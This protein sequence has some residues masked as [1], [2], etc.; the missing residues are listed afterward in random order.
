M[1]TIDRMELAD[2]GNPVQL[3]K[4]VIGQ[5]S[6][7]IL[8]VPVRDIAASLDI[9]EIKPITVSGFE[10]G[11]ITFDDKSSGCILINENSRPQ[12]QRFTIGHELGHY[13]NP[14][15]N[16]GSEG[17]FMCKAQDM[18]ASGNPV[19]GRQKM[20]V[21]A[22]QFSAELLMPSQF[23][24]DDVKRLNAPEIDHIV[25]LAT[26]YDVSKESMGRR[27]IEFQDEPCALVF[28][29]NGKLSYMV[30]GQ[31]FPQLSIWQ[32]GDAIPE[33]SLTKTYNDQSGNSSDWREHA[34]DIWL[35]NSNKYESVYEQVLLQ[36][37]G[38]RIT[39]LTLGDEAD[40][41]EEELVA[42]YKPRFR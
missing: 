37:N 33:N 5:I 2:I 3:A 31:Y 32:K 40:E 9:A 10:G 34:S 28:S 42:S 12:R 24:R 26:K 15:H 8:P 19:G 16:P 39:L 25:A 41:D 29:R 38:Y 27:Y 11:L 1:V 36:E 20:E 13:L 30:K 21:E 7:I 18:V 17:Q 4:A 22:N 14:W 6:D 23:M 35:R